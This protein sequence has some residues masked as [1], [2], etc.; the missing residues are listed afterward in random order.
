MAYAKPP[1]RSEHEWKAMRHYIANPIEAVKDWFK[2]TPDPWQADTLNGLFVSG[3]DRVSAKAAHGVGKTTVDAWAGWIFLNCYENCRVVATAPTAAQLRDVLFPEFAKWQSKMPERMKNEW[4]LSQDH[5]RHKGAPKQWFAVSRTSNNPANLQG[6]HG[7]HLFIIGDEASAIPEPVFE[8]IEGALSEAG[9]DGKVAKLLLNGNPNFT[10]GELYNSFTRNREMYYRITISGDP[11]FAPSIDHPGDGTDHKEHGHLYYSTRVK[12]RYVKNMESK[13]GRDSAVFDV[14]VRGIFP[15]AADDAVIPFEWAQRA[16]SLT[17]PALFDNIAH[18][19]RLV[20]D[21]SRGGG[22][23][24]VIGFERRGVVV[25]MMAHK[26]T[27]TTQIVHLIQEARLSVLGEGTTVSEVVVDEPGVG[28]G[29][30][31]QLRQLGVV[32]TPYHGGRAMVRGVDPD[33]DIRMFAN[34]KSRDWWNVRRLFEQGLLPIPDDELLV[35]QL[36]SVKFTYRRGDD[37]ILVES[38]EDLKN[39]LGKEASPD[40]AD[41][42]VMAAARRF[43][44]G[45]AHAGLREEDVDYG[46]D[47]PQMEMDL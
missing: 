41:V 19:Y 44:E 24:T 38:K 23:E 31:D 18:P 35:N 29:V 14:R 7:E 1:P 42:I 6:F 46:E 8:V 3:L 34:R 40:R 36:A 17:P 16:A 33:E 21:V 13:Y 39:R 25:K 15:R 10:T 26:T 4:E 43:E 28:G 45:V 22:A 2:V 30:I 12:P 5:I 11:E 32:V 37:K 27:T 9:D 47:R 20:V